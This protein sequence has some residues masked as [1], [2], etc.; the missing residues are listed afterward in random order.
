M[1]DIFKLGSILFIITAVAAVLLGF[2]NM[3]TSK[4]IA[5]REKQERAEALQVV[6]KEASEFE[7]VEELPLDGTIISEINVGKTNGKIVGYT[8]NVLPTGYGGEINML[9]G[10]SSEGKL[11]GIE[12]LAHNETPGLGAKAVEPEFKNQ[13]LGKSVDSSLNLVKGSAAAENEI[14]AISGATITS[15]AVTDAVNAA[16]DLYNR[17]LK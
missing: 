1:R 12:I 7:I 8:F 13:F 6:L 3:A 9:V 16:I 2:T 17:S 14:Q 4:V 15:T 5:E 10:I 11:T